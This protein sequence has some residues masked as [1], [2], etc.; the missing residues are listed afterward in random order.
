MLSIQQHATADPVSGLREMLAFFQAHYPAQG[1]E[2]WRERIVRWLF[3]EDLDRIIN[4]ITLNHWKF[5][6]R[7]L[8]APALYLQAQTARFVPVWSAPIISICF[9]L[10]IMAAIDKLLGK[11][12]TSKGL[13]SWLCLAAMILID[14]AAVAPSIGSLLLISHQRLEDRQ[15]V[16]ALL[17]PELVR[18]SPLF[19]GNAVSFLG[20]TSFWW[21]LA[22]ALVVP[23]SLASEGFWCIPLAELPADKQRAI[24]D[25]LS[26]AQQICP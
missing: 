14:V 15:F 9:V 1:R 5:Y 19:H 4:S 16:E 22:F 13:I 11:G 7:Y 2:P 26:G 12:T 8:L 24:F 20:H 23:L 10:L 21:A 18:L 6:N 17:S 3:Y 25:R